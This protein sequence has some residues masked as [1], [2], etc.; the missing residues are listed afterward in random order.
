MAG[1]PRAVA[2]AALLVAAPA[3]AGCL[4]Y[5]P[6]PAG[7]CGDAAAW[8]DRLVG[9]QPG[10]HDALG[11]AAAQANAS[12]NRS[13]LPSRQAAWSSAPV[14]VE[15]TS[16]GGLRHVAV[17]PVQGLN[18]TDP[19][20]EALDGFG[21]LLVDQ[22]TWFPEGSSSP[23]LVYDAADRPGANRT[24]MFRF[25]P[26][27]GDPDVR[28]RM[29]EAFVAALFPDADPDEVVGDGAWTGPRPVDAEADVPGLLASVQGQASVRTEPAAPEA[30]P[31]VGGVAVVEAPGPGNL[32]GT[33]QVDLAY[34][35]RA[36]AASTA[37]PP[38][39]VEAAAGGRVAVAAYADEPV[40]RDALT[41]LAADGLQ[42]HLGPHALDLEDARYASATCP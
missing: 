6:A 25:L 5:T 26:E 2:A 7:A 41:A 8:S 17:R 18:A 33:L 38:W 42:E 30:A 13:D 4:A 28:E 35:L 10:L 21:P 40:G 37:E 12:G 36:V 19:P 24:L 3:A 23:Q 14:T 39:S 34:G 9:S 20:G 11:R 22:V 32:S 27:V 16:A 31:R 29:G 1:L 15:V